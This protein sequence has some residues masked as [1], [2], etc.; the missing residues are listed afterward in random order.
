MPSPEADLPFSVPIPFVE[1]LGLRLRR[2]DDGVAEIAF[3]PGPQ[4]LNSFAVVHGGVSMTLLDVAMAHA[5]RSVQRDLGVVTIEMK[6]SFLQAAQ[7]LLR[8]HGRLL[9]RTA[10]L[11]FTEGEIRDAAGRLC[12]HGSGT[13]RYVRRLPTPQRGVH[14]FGAV[15]PPPA[16]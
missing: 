7:G 10:T 15:P 13:F 1:L 6:T 8:A 12:A 5:A 16:E 2:W 9:H 14:R 3:E 4:H 11:A